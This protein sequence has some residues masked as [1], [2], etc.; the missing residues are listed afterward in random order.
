MHTLAQ[1]A[2]RADMIGMVMR[3]QNAIDIP[4]VKPHLTQV[5]LNL[6][7]RYAGI[8]ENAAAAR[9]KVIAIAATATRKTPEYESLFLHFYKNRA[10]NYSKKTIF[11]NNSTNFY[12]ILAYIKKK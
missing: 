4:V 6:A 1:S 10:Q 8:N 3:N 11:A 9:T 5:F 2:Y 7:R 12:K